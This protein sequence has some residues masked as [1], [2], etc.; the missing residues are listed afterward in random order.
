[1]SWDLENFSKFQIPV[2]TAAVREQTVDI[3]LIPHVAVTNREQT[4]DIP[5][6]PHFAVANREQKVDILA[7]TAKCGNKLGT[8]SGCRK[9]RYRSGSTLLPSRKMDTKMNNAQVMRDLN[10]GR[11]YRF[12]RVKLAVTCTLTDQNSTGYVEHHADPVGLSGQR[13]HGEPILVVGYLSRNPDADE[14]R[15]GLRH[16]QCVREVAGLS[17][18]SGGVGPSELKEDLCSK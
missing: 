15:V 6:I 10:S 7:D 18:W 17:V 8:D 2:Y 4:V 11:V 1:M 12:V 14:L 13:P 5:L 16:V 9:L 3:L